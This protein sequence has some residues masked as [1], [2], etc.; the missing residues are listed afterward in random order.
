[1]AWPA[2]PDE[3]GDGGDIDDAPG[4]LLDHR[5]LDGLDEIEGALEIR[6]DD[7]VPILL[8]HAH[9]KAI[10]GEAGVVDQDVDAGEIG[11]DLLDERLH[12]GVVGDVHGVG[13]GQAGVL[14]VD[15]IGGALGIRLRAGNHG[16]ARAF[17]GEAQG[18][19]VADAAAGAGDDGDLIGESHKGA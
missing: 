19:G 12:G 2:L 7:H 4:A 14:R 17:A 18:D 16:H 9:G 1:M 8:G 13:L 5:A 11:E 15:L 3:P 6:I 10:A